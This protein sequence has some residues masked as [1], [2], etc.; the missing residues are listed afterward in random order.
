ME[1]I[2]LEA[3]QHELKALRTEVNEL[4]TLLAGKTPTKSGSIDSE[5]SEFLLDLRIPANVKGFVFLREAIKMSYQDFENV[6]G[7]FKCIYPAIAEKY[8]TQVNRVERNIRHAIESS[9]Y[10]Y[11]EHPFYQAYFPK[12]KPTNGAVIAMIADQFLLEAATS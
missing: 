7:L 2:Q 8:D 9:W 5:I 11:P 6:D 12:D 10:R 1:T 4:K 3:I